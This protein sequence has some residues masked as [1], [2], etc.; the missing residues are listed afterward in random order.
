MMH[1]QQTGLGHGDQRPVGA[2]V[3]GPSIAGNFLSDTGPAGDTRLGKPLLQLFLGDL[4]LKESRCY[5][6]HF[7]KLE[8]EPVVSS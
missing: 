4:L 2:R 1:G 7:T 8:S 6:F 5:T 3:A